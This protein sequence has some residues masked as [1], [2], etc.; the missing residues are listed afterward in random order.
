MNDKKVW[1]TKQMVD[2]VKSICDNEVEIEKQFPGEHFTDE[3]MI[4]VGEHTL[5][6]GGFVSDGDLVNP[7]FD[8][9]EYIYLYDEI[10]DGLKVK[11]EDTRKLYFQIKDVLEEVG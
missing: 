5:I 11:H 1:N 9:I 8:E 6:M 3:I 7:S 2:L 4:T 10:G